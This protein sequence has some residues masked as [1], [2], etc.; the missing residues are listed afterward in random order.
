MGRPRKLLTVEQTS[1]ALG[2]SISTVWRRIRKGEIPTVR[3]G[4]RRWVPKRSVQTRTKRIEAKLPLFTR[5]HPIFSMVGA[6]RSGGAGP[7]S[8]DKYAVLIDDP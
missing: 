3:V 6:Y 2:V 1:K 8:S 5:D 7:G 4:A